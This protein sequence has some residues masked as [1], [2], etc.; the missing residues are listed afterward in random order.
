MQHSLGSVCLGARRIELLRLGD[1]RAREL[2]HRINQHR[3]EERQNRVRRAQLRPCA[4]KRRIAGKRSL[5]IQELR[6]VTQALTEAGIK[7]TGVKTDATLHKDY[8]AFKD[9]DGIAW[10]LYMM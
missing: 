4:R 10:E 8:V 7:N 1:G 2:G 9:P 5:E 6:R 3:R